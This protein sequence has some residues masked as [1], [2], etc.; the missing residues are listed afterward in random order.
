MDRNFTPRSATN[1]LNT[2]PFGAVFF[3]Q[4]LAEKTSA[5]ELAEVCKNTCPSAAQLRRTTRA[6]KNSLSQVEETAV[7]NFL[8]LLGTL[9]FRKALQ[10]SLPVNSPHVPR[11]DSEGE[12]VFDT[13]LLD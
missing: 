11:K 8:E 13:V 4:K 1:S 10:D 3:P 9:Q 12:G 2:M 6:S 5:R 7:V